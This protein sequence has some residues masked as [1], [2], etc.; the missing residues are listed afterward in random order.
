MSISVQVFKE[1][2][3]L[4]D[5]SQCSGAQWVGAQAPILE[6]HQSL[7]DVNCLFGSLFFFLKQSMQAELPISIRQCCYFHILKTEGHTEAT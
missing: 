7:T 1:Y 2:M 4:D 3:R 6:A 5:C